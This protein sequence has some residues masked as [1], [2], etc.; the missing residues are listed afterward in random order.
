MPP[1]PSLSQGHGG[2][3]DFDENDA[4]GDLGENEEAA[5]KMVAATLVV[6]TSL[7]CMC[8]I[9]CGCTRFVRRIG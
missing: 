9:T 8:L 3:F 2:T 1:T 6:A 7:L 5:L 4:G